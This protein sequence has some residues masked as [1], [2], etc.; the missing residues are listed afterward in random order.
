MFNK[1]DS[2]LWGTIAL[3]ALILFQRARELIQQCTLMFKGEE[4]DI[5]KSREL[6]YILST[7]FN[8]TIVFNHCLIQLMNGIF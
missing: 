8:N 6:V 7:Q 5:I 1:F 2:P 3:H 4:Y